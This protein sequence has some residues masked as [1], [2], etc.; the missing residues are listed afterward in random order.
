LKH[1]INAVP[2]TWQF[3]QQ[4]LHIIRRYIMTSSFKLIALKSTVVAV[5]LAAAPMVHAAGTNQAYEEFSGTHASAIYAVQPSETRNIGVDRVAANET[6]AAFEQF[7]G[8][9][10][11]VKTAHA[12]MAGK[13]GEIGEPGRAGPHRNGASSLFDI[14]G[15]VAG[16]CAKYLRCSAY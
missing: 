2:P 3:S 1:E 13:P 9:H 10:A 11:A 6:N 7:S 4:T 8:T 16:G 12:G 15:D 14:N 5:V